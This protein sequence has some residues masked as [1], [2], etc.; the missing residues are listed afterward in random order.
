M[1]FPPDPGQGSGS[2]T[3]SIRTISAAAYS[4]NSSDATIRANAIGGA[5]VITLMAASA[6]FGKVITIKK[7]D[8]SA[9]MVTIM[10]QSGDTIDGV[11]SL[12]ISNQESSFT[13]QSN[14]VSWDI[15]GSV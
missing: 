5:I 6:A 7:V 14:G 12:G 15:V 3:T 9:N 1:A 11:T 10:P 13:I 2:L 4:V 8:A